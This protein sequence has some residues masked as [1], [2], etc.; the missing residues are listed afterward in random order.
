MAAPGR[1]PLSAVWRFLTSPV[2]RAVFALTVV[3]AM[4]CL[5]HAEGAFH[6]LSTHRDMLRYISVYGMLAC[7]MTLVIVSGGIDLAVG[8]I[9]ALVAVCFSLMTIHWGYSPWIAV[10]LSLAIGAACGGLSGV[11]TSRFGVQ[12]F[13]ATLAMMVFAR[14]LAKRISGGEQVN[15][16]IEGPDGMTDW[17]DLPAIFNAI[18]STLFKESPFNVYLMLAVLILALVTL[19]VW[20]ILRLTRCGQRMLANIYDRVASLLS[21]SWARAIAVILYIAIP[22]IAVVAGT[23]LFGKSLSRVTVIFLVAAIITWLFL[24][25]YRWGRYLYAIGGNEQAALLSG[26]PVRRVKTLAYA[27]SGM[28]AALAG[29]CH[30]A[31]ETQGDPNAGVSYELTAIA[32]VVV[33]GTNLMADAV[34]S[35]SR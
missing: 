19:F 24:A 15:N 16:I 21:P 34:V 29:I 6:K 33:G 23:C 31:Q 12:P 7:G 13:I 1:D 27:A 20:G 5:F 2:G 25:R 17:V 8:S 3:I 18:D 10:P 22:L 32:M 30:A 28:L 35:G 14:G 4:G 11:V 26:I 9:L